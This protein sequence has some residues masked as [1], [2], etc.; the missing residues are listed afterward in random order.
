MS[1]TLISWL[2]KDGVFDFLKDLIIRSS[3]SFVEKAANK[4]LEK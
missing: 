1:K 4:H 3:S 2:Q